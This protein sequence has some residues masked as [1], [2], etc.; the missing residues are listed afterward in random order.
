LLTNILVKTI[1]VILSALVICENGIGTSAIL[2]AR[3]KKEFP[4]IKQIKVSRVSTLN[5]IDLSQ[6]NL[7]FSTLKLKGFSRDYQ[8]VS[9]LACWI[10]KL[11]GSR[12]ILQDY[13]AKYPLDSRYAQPIVENHHKDSAARLV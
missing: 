12:I 7:I 13:E 1:T 2:S 6:Y 10:M 8:L 9:P 11:N 5:Q 4:E 3:L